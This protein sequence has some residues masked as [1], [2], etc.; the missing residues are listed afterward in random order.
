M[1]EEGH[2]TGAAQ[3][4]GRSFVPVAYFTDRLRTGWRPIEVA[5]F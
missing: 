1:G 2:C 5:E 4:A 3:P